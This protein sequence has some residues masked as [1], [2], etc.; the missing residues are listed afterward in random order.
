MTTSKSVAF[1]TINRTAIRKE[2]TVI[3]TQSA[4][5][6][7]QRQTR[8]SIDERLERIQLKNELELTDEELGN[9]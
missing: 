5:E 8:L 9:L 4:A 1:N 3:K 7:K 6:K 2:S